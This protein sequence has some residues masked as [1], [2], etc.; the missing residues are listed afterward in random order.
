M[1]SFKVNLTIVGVFVLAALATLV[2][3]LAVLAGRTGPTD[4]Y[5][6][7]YSNVAGLKFGS[8]VMFEG[9]PIGQV[10]EVDPMSGDSRLRFRVEI[11]IARG[12]Q[13]PDDSIARSVSPGVLAPQTIA[14]TAGK[15]QTML[16]PGDTIP[17]AVSV[18]FQDSFSSIAGSFDELTAQSLVPLVD[19]INRQVTLLGEMID[20]DM[21]PLIA[22]ANRFMQAT[23]ERWPAIM[24]NAESASGNLAGMSTELQTLLSADRIA[25]LDRLITNLDQTAINMARASATLDTLAKGSG[26]DLKVGLEEFRF[27]METISRHAE[28]VAQNVDSSALNLQEF[29]RSIR[30]NPGVLLRAPEAKEDPVPPLRRKE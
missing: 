3:A 20:K 29:S 2:I 22:N 13:I 11:S 18:S 19:N 10:E 26:D 27:T 16:K 23:A 17:S 30:Q 28:S 21:K 1:T 12:W 15:S 5:Y 8:Q 4:T 25:A 6:T 7:E 9:Y 24:K 14:I